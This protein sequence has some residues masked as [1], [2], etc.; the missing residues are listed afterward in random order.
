MSKINLSELPNTILAR[1]DSATISVSCL[2]SP[3]IGLSGSLQ[4]KFTIDQITI[5]S[6]FSVLIKKDDNHL[7]I[8]R[9]LNGIGRLMYFDNENRLYAEM[10]F[11]EELFNVFLDRVK[12]GNILSCSLSV[13]GL[14]ST[15]SWGDDISS[16][17]WDLRNRHISIKDISIHENI[18]FK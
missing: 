6:D 4:N 7:E 13:L 17:E 8:E 10:F 11:G 1:F 2:N 12:N 14:V 16:Y 18:K 9:A 3:T 5:D 15:A